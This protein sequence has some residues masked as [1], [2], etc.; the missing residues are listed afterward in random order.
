MCQRVQEV[1][2]T[3]D[4]FLLTTHQDP[5]GDGLGSEAALA[6][7]LAQFGKSVQVVNADPV[8]KQYRFLAK[9]DAFRVYQPEA[10]DKLLANINVVVLLDTSSPERTGCLA[11]ALARFDGMTV[12]IDHHTSS[13]WAQLEMID[14]TMSAVAELV[15]EVIAGLPVNMSP[16][17]AEALFTGLVADTQGFTVNTTP[18]LHL[19]AASL[20]QEGASAERVQGALFCSWNLGRLRLLGEFLAHL[21]MFNTFLLP[22]VWSTQ[23]MEQLLFLL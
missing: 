20:L 1:L 16:T 5:D 8:P 10:H 2:R 6:E 3:K 11:P 9:S 19:L 12:A 17:M 14:C 18:Q 15:Y 7:A 21:Q 22:V 13:G 4:S 23:S